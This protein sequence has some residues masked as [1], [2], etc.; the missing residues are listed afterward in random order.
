MIYKS[1]KKVAYIFSDAFDFPSRSSELAPGAALAC[2][3]VV[4]PRFWR[5]VERVGIAPPQ[6]PWSIWFPFRPHVRLGS[7][8]QSLHV[9]QW[10]C[11]VTS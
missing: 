11:F 8:R 3:P 6:T 9:V 2:M 10:R 4:L 1:A 5:W 7:F